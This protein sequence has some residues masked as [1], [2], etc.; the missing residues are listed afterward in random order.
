MESLLEQAVDSGLRL[1]ITFVLMGT[2]G[3]VSSCRYSRAANGEWDR[4]L[5]VQTKEQPDVFPAHLFWSDA[6]GNFF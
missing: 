6:G 2:N 3:Y 4:T 5:L 1:P